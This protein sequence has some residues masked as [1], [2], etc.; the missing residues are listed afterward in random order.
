[1]QL[2][3]E[4]L[5]LTPLVAGDARCLWPILSDART[6]RHW[7]QPYSYAE[8]EGWVRRALAVREKIGLSRCLL[9]RRS[10]GRVIGDCGLFILPV[11]D[12]PEALDLGWMVHWPFQGEGYATEAAR[13][14]RDHAL[15]P[16]GLGRLV[17][18]LNWKNHPSRRVAEKIGARFV[19]RFYNARYRWTPTDLFELRG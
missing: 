8:V 10:D 4:R 18:N 5:I 19:R 13:T 14:I 2:E 12:E 9:R 16:L 7:P 6:M 1:M 11:A 17:V 15:G 3:T